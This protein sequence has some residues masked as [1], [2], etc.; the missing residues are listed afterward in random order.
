MVTGVDMDIANSSRNPK[1]KQEENDSYMGKKAASNLHMIV[2]TE[3]R[4]HIILKRIERLVIIIQ[5]MHVPYTDEIIADIW[6]MAEYQT[7]ANM[8][9]LMTPQI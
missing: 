3:I 7:S 5:E 2:L 4:I 6:I 9:S 1:K 8:L